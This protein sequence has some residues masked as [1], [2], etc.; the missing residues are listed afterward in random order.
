[1]TI[2]INQNINYIT[3]TL[4]IISTTYP[5]AKINADVYYLLF[6]P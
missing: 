5:E 3:I 4:I 6:R 1:M 2:E